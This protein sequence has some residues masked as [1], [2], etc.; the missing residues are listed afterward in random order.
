[1]RWIVLCAL[2]A[3]AVHA[4]PLRPEMRPNTWPT[5]RPTA[6]LCGVPGLVGERRPTFT[7][8]IGGCGIDAPVLVRQVQSVRLSRP[9]LLH[10]D[11]ARALNDFASGTL[12]R[13]VDGRFGG[14]VE[15]NVAAHYAC[16]TRNNR[17]G[18]K[19]SEHAKGRAI[20]IS[21]FTFAD[22]TKMT[23]LDDW[24]K[25]VKGAML[26]KIWDGACGDFGTV[27]GPDADR[28]HQDH[29]HLDVAAYRGGSYCR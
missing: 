13:A 6:P 10:C 12:R 11:A 24:G 15:M 25:G 26:R 17:A 29:F 16:R 28:F 9:A 3:G 2:L 4:Q 22:G 23:L 27:L 5:A 21:A 19:L 14:V 7:G 20:D 1:M 18:A 8:N